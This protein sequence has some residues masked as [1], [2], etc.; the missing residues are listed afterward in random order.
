MS[1]TT[2]PICSA[3]QQTAM[4]RF[5]IFFRICVVAILLACIP[6]SVFACTVELAINNLKLDATAS[7]GTYARDA[8]KLLDEM[9]FLTSKAKIP[10]VPINQQLSAND[11]KRFQELRE[12]LIRKQM[13]ELYISWFE[14]DVFIIGEVAKSSEL[15]SKGASFSET[16]P[17]KT[18]LTFCC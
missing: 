12:E 14:R 15:I 1:A 5:N 6:F 11:V 4:F 8:T 2:K 3:E 13:Q 17:Q 18:I 16:D 7:R 9:S 10:N